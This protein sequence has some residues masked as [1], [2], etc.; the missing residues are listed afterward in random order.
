MN[1]TKA[2][3]GAS[4]I[5]A[6]PGLIIGLL[7]LLIPTDFLLKL[8]FVVM[9]VI[10]VLSSIPGLVAGA[11]TFSTGA[12]KLS[13]IVSLISAIVGFLMIFNHNDILM[14]VLGVYMIALPILNVILAK[15]HLAQF[16]AELPKLIIGLLLVIL[17]PAKTLDTLFRVAGWVVIAFTVLSSVA[18]FFKVKRAARVHI[19]SGRGHLFVD[20]DGDG[21]VDAVFVD[22]TGDGKPDTEVEYRR[23]K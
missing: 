17:G 5:L 6:I 14:I 3:L 4:L 22:T 1:R 19:S 15:D 21:T 18:V 13:V 2:A 23:D 12:G 20:K 9:G 8:I 10:T 16:K 11:A 7:L